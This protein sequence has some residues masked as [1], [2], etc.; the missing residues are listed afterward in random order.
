MIELPPEREIG[1]R[2]ARV[3]RAAAAGSLVPP[4]RAVRPGLP[5]QTIVVG[6][7]GKETAANPLAAAVRLASALGAELHIM[8][9]YS[10]LQAPSD[11]EAALAEATGVAREEGVEAVYHARRDDP[12]DALIAVAEDLD[13]ELLVVGNKGK[14][15]TS[16]LLLGSVADTVAHHAPCSILIVRTHGL[17]TGNRAIVPASE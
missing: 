16:R 17:P 13:A 15:S 11:A 4:R 6:T 10:A 8:S 5:L 9:A 12:A 1:T 14:S 7:D 2:L 3:L